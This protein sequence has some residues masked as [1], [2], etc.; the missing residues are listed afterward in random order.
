LNR[1]SSSYTP[2]PEQSTGKKVGQNFSVSIYIAAL[3]EKNLSAGYHGSIVNPQSESALTH[4]ALSKG[5]ET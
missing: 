1:L 2:L 3:K 4:F 5:P